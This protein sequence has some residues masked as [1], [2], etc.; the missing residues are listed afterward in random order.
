MIMT[1]KM[2][3]TSA[4]RKNLGLLMQL[5][6]PQF[7]ERPKSNRQKKEANT[8]LMKVVITQ[9]HLVTEMTMKKTPTSMAPKKI[10]M[11][12]HRKMVSV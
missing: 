12:L 9:M 3:E 2:E 5:N 8:K 6:F 10:L 4:E 1:E 11:D 7:L